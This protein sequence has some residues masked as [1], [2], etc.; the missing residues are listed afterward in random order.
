M[1][2]MLMGIAAVTQMYVFHEA[3]NRWRN[4]KIH[5]LC[6]SVLQIFWLY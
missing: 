2:L 3:M 1:N 4:L 5:H 6:I